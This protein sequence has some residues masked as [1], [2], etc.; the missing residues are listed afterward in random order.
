MPVGTAE[1]PRP[2][3]SGRTRVAAVIGSPVSHSRSPG[4]HN[5]AFEAL[6]LDWVYVALECP[7]GSAG[8]ALD[9]M[10][11]L[12][13]GGL[14]VTMP[15]K[16][17]VARRLDDLDPLAA[18]LGAVNCVARDGD[19][20][21]GHNT[22]AS[23]FPAWLDSAGHPLADAV[24]AVIGAGGAGRAVVAGA[25]DAGAQRVLVVNRSAER[26]GEAIAL[27]PSRCVAGDTADLRSAD[28]VVNATPVG[29][30]GTPGLPVDLSLLRPDAVV[31]DLVY[32]P[33]ETDLVRAARERGMVALDGL[34]M[35]VHQAVGAF[36]LWTGVEA[37]LE[38]MLRAATQR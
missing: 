19:G 10:A 7:A 23:G 36:R 15:H 2:P 12:G 25:L 24:V 1:G 17:D 35:L 28:V 6:G 22:D 20:L 3:I 11:T 32:D 30:S 18:R 16:E 31:A 14:S 34:G 4:I 38:V 5:A 13:L 33:V 9:A 29:M 37:P 26:S 21:V 27:D 8:L